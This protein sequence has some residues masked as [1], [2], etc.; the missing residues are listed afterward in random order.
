M[1]EITMVERKPSAWVGAMVG[2]LLVGIVVG[3]AVDRA[4]VWQAKRAEASSAAAVEEARK[5][6]SKD[7]ADALKVALIGKWDCENGAITEFLKD[8][9]F[10][11][12]FKQTVPN[13]GADGFVNFSN[14]V[15]SQSVQVRGQ[16]EWTGEDAVEMRVAGKPFYK[17]RVAIEGE[18]MKLLAE[19]GTV[20]KFVR[21]K[22]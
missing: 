2:V 13:A 4:M 18:G 6:A 15:R 3:M 7:R 17:L 1:N 19:D 8:G 12:N 22:G 5:K 16:Y 14:P 20:T 21:R 10:E 9:T 11:D